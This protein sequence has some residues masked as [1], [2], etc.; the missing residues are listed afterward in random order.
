MSDIKKVKKADKIY[1][2]KL[3]SLSKEFLFKSRL[4][5]SQAPDEGVENLRI[6]ETTQMFEKS[7]KT[8]SGRITDDCPPGKK[9][10]RAT[11]LC[12]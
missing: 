9:P 5:I 2:E 10:D 11:G 8:L 6:K 4:Y 12:V 1:D 7:I 3:N